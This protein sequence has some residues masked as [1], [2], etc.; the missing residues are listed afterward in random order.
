MPLA[1][2]VDAAGTCF[3]TIKNPHIAISV[4]L[5]VCMHGTATYKSITVE[6]LYFGHLWTGKCVPN[7]EVPSFQ[8]SKCNDHNV[9]DRALEGCP[10]FRSALTSGV[11]LFQGCPYFMGFPI[12]GMSL[13]QGCSDRGVSLYYR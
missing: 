12:P 2:S 3:F 11:S 10:N 9:W 13:F 4:F 7:R 6:P 8:G 1:H 5:D